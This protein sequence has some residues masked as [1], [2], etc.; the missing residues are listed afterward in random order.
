MC[1]Q[2]AAQI[3]QNAANAGSLVILFNMLHKIF[4]IFYSLNKVDIPVYFEDHLKEWMEI[5]LKFLKYQTNVPQIA[6]SE[7][8]ID[9]SLLHKVQSEIAQNI[10]LYIEKYEMEFEPF[11]AT[12][13]SA[14]WELLKK[15]SQEQASDLLASSLMKFLSSTARSCHHKIFAQPATLKSMIEEVVLPNIQIRESDI[16]MFED[17]PDKYMQKD[18]EGSDLETRRR[19]ASDLVVGLRKHY[20][21]HVTTLCGEHINTLFTQYKAN[22]GTNWKA[23]DGAIYL[24]IALA[25]TG[26][27][28]SDGVTNVNTAV[29]LNDI[30]VNQIM[31][32]LTGAAQCHP[33][34]LA[35][36]LKF[37]TSFRS[38]LFMTGKAANV[39]G[40]QQLFPH[41]MKYLTHELFIVHTYAALAIERI[42]YMC[43]KAKALEFIATLGPSVEQILS[44]LFKILE[45]GNKSDSDNKY[46]M[47]AVLRVVST[48]RSHMQP[49]VQLMLQ[50][51]TGTLQKHYKNPL[52]PN[53][54]HNLFETM[55]SLVSTFCTAN[56]AAVQ[57]FEKFLF[58]VFQAIVQE[59]DHVY[60]PYVFQVMAQLL[61]FNQGS[62]NEF[63][64]NTLDFILLAKV[65]KER[66]NVPALIRVISAYLRIDVKYVLDNNKLAPIL[67]IFQKLI[68]STA[69]T[70]HA[71]M[72]L[73]AIILY[74]PPEALAQPIG[75]Q[76][77]LPIIFRL[78]FGRLTSEKL[79]ISFNNHF[80]VFLSFLIGKRGVDFTIQT[81]NGIQANSF[82]AVFK[83]FVLPKFKGVS[84]TLE[85]KML[86]I[87]MSKLLTECKDML[88]GSLSEYWGKTL[89]ALLEMLSKGTDLTV[90]TAPSAEGTQIVKVI[91][92]ETVSN[93]YSTVFSPLIHGVKAEL[94]DPF[95]EVKSAKMY[96][97]TAL[98]KLSQQVSLQQQL[99]QL[100]GDQQVLLQNYCKA[101]NVQI[102]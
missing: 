70:H 79:S 35:D 49:H 4:G 53:F 58:P 21:Q 2:T 33:L 34:V 24:T 48:C 66:G 91:P 76:H 81:M 101:A 82:Q 64:K 77:V 51:I 45:S 73:E 74:V 30:F 1:Q 62:L 20:Q 96:L 86:T 13:T 26:T 7:D 97:I 56:R 52:N 50:R 89:S 8:D 94:V 59:E 5:F 43:F 92:D 17:E 12:L 15:T 38:T 71:F 32:E 29:P 99:S 3:D 11:L 95:A 100:P 27:T 22:P 60:T 23:K 14:V 85:R 42:L 47:R 90:D 80:I 84:G 19:G 31:P 69:L 39:Q 10:N 37:V 78:L 18:I 75:G 9:P 46:V 44:G 61:E 102:R 83:K 40:L 63:Y 67:G 6:Q 87:G 68:S 16:E 54:T 55:A 25:A 57:D 36:C 28:A 88:G 41:F 72:L 98:S 93:A 65:W